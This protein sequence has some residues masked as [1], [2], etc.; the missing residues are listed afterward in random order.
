MTG[1]PRAF[2][3]PDLRLNPSEWAYLAAFVDA[4]GC[5]GYYWC[6]NYWQAR[7]TI[8]QIDRR[9]IDWIVERF[10]GKCVREKARFKWGI[11][12]REHVRWLLEG[13]L[14]YLVLKRDK[15]VEV[16]DAIE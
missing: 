2:T 15:A 7:I 14:D 3:P 6:R 1:K 4:D 5:I 9:P 8:T 10:G 13:M 12:S 16:L 11:Y